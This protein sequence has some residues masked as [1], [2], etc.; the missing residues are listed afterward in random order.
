MTI[1]IHLFS[2][3]VSQYYITDYFLFW[4]TPKFSAN[5][6]FHNYFN[7]IIF[8]IYRLYQ[9][10]S[11]FQF[12]SVDIL[13]HV[14]AGPDCPAVQ[15]AQAAPP[16]QGTKV[17]PQGPKGAIV[18]VSNLFCIL[19]LKMFVQDRTA[20]SIQSTVLGFIGIPPI[21]VPSHGTPPNQDPS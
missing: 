19:K 1:F 12:H 14:D 9:I 20:L 15:G 7:Y 16:V 6:I 4:Y 11:Y 18:Y 3:V 2:L 5:L 13:R 10:L 21:Q 17:L 8:S